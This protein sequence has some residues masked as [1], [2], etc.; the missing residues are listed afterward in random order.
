MTLHFNLKLEIPLSFFVKNAKNED[1]KKIKIGQF[2]YILNS[3]HFQKM[4]ADEKLITVI[5][6]L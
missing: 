3:L 1:E 4:H 5:S 2:I 6:Q